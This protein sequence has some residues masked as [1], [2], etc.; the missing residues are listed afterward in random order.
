MRRPAERHAFLEF[1]VAVLITK[2]VLGAGLQQRD[3]AVGTDRAGIDADHADIVGHALA[4]KRTGKGHQRGVAGAAADIVGVELLAGRADVVDD[5]AAAARLHLGIDGAGEV[6]VAEHLQFP[7]MTP[8]CFVNLVNRAA[9]NV[10][11]I[12]DENVD[13]GGVLRQPR[14]VF[15]F[16]QVGDVGGGVDLVLRAQPVG[17]RLQRLAAAG[18]QPQMAAFL[19]KGFGRGRANALGGAGDQDA[20]AAQ[21][22]I[23][24]FFFLAGWNFGG[25]TAEMDRRNA[26]AVNI[27]LQRCTAAE[28]GSL[29]GFPA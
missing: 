7:G 9:G 24:G 12:V 21:V 14:N 1:L 11:G 25:G 28:I 29:Q 8:G 16:A 3:M 18:S 26:V 17:Q 10:A 15:R 6:D 20:L 2:L 13:V 27:A 22:Q 23:H 5:H 4:A 19:G